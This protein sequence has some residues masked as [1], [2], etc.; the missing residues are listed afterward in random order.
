[1]KRTTQKAYNPLKEVLSMKRGTIACQKCGRRREERVCP[2]CGY[3]ACCI[4]IGSDGKEYRF[5]YDKNG[6]PFTFHTALE[7]LISINN[8][9]KEHIFNPKDYERRTIDERLFQNA[10]ERFLEKKEAS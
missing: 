10:F 4:R 3:D 2:R 9:I 8:Q 6:K 5:F 1:M 7:T